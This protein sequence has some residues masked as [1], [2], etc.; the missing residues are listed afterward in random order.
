LNAIEARDVEKRYGSL[1]ALRDFSLDLPGG[2]FTLVCG[3]NGAGK[4]TLLRVLAGLTRPT[5]GTIRLLGRDPFG[6][7]ARS[8]RGEIG[9]LG[10]Q[11]GLYADLTVEENLEFASGLHGVDGAHVDR[12]LG[13]LGL[14]A[15][16]GRR[17]R[18]L[19]Q[20]YRRRVGFARALVHD[21]KILVL[22]EPWNGLD[23]EASERLVKLLRERR[24]RGATVIVAAHRA[25]AG[26]D[27]TDGVIQ[28]DQ[29]QLVSQ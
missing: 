18:V 9:W 12:L 15:V 21:P 5:A 24:D 19:S 13:Q 22:D 3:P 8:I 26:E 17:V 23:D 25:P 29:G 20:G 6:K 7:D 10:S 4:S 11:A 27:T 1:R 28:L 16:R 14:E 2:T